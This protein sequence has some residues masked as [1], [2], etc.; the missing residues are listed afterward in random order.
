MQIEIL[1]FLLDAS[2]HLRSAACTD[3]DTEHLDDLQAVDRDLPDCDWFELG[4]ERE[5]ARRTAD[6]LWAERRIQLEF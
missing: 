2:A 6:E 1:K 4:E 3:T 5:A